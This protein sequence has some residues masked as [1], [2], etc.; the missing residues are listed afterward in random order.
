VW[1]TKGL[2]LGVSLMSFGEIIE[3]IFI[4]LQAVYI[5]AKSSVQKNKACFS[6]EQKKTFNSQKRAESKGMSEEKEN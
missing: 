5:R 6:V 1:S 2:F 3:L 4:C